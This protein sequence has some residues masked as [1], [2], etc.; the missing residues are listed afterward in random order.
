MKGHMMSYKD[1][2]KNVPSS[3]SSKTAEKKPEAPNKDPNPAK[4]A[5]E[6]KS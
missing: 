5:K 1:L 4:E 2:P 3:D 6:N